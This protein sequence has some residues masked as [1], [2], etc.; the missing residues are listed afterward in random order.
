MQPTFTPKWYLVKGADSDTFQA[1]TE[2]ANLL[3]SVLTYF[4][5]EKPLSGLSSLDYDI[6]PEYFQSPEARFLWEVTLSMVDSNLAFDLPTFFSACC[7]KYTKDY[8]EP[9][10]KKLAASIGEF[11]TGAFQT[12]T[13]INYH[14]RKVLE[15]YY[16]REMRETLKSS[17]P[18][19]FQK[20]IELQNKIQDLSRLDAKINSTH[21]TAPTLSNNLIEELENRMNN[22]DQHTNCRWY[23]ERHDEAMPIG[24]GHLIVIGGRSGHGKT[25]YTLNLLNKMLSNHK[26][27]ALFTLEMSSIEITQTLMS[28]ITR[29]PYRSFDRPQGLTQDQIDYIYAGTKRIYQTNFMCV[30]E[31][32]LSVE[33]IRTKSL[34]IKKQ[35][36]GL[37]AIFID[38]IHIMGP[39]DKRFNSIREQIIH[40][41]GELKNIAKELK[42]P[43]FALAQMNRAAENRADKT[44]MVSDLKESGSLEQDA[45]TIV[46]TYRDTEVDKENPESYIICRKN[47]HGDKTNFKIHMDVDPIVRIFKEA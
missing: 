7:D 26:K 17:Q 38:H 39:G 12:F 6:Q 37:D 42:V 21:M 31:P 16:R 3:G 32:R 24:R 47:R 29:I 13:N 5:E 1:K 4:N 34:L 20:G 27:A 40:I 8:K 44:P 15:C 46:F 43:I 14:A 30:D 45:D 18:D 41:S 25:T 33:D 35:L 10:P 23:Y 19:A 36:G 9:P 22:P 11:G 28:Q 2:E